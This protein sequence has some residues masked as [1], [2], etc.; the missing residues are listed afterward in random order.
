MMV[1]HLDTNDART[2]KAI[3][4]AAGAAG[5]AKCHTAD[6]RKMYGVP[7]SGDPLHL[8]LV[9][10]ETCTCDDFR[11]REL[12]CKHVLAVRLHVGLVKAT[13]PSQSKL[14]ATREDADVVPWN[15][16]KAKQYDDIFSKFD[17]D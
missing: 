4:I 9:T 8:Y 15:R 10:C 16:A 17:G 11:R 7:A 2:V 1:I 6:G 13:H 3:Q 5:W 14:V 12:A